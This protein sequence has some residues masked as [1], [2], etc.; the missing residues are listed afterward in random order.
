[1]TFCIENSHMVFTE[2]SSDFLK[3]VRFTIGPGKQTI[4]FVKHES[5]NN[6]SYQ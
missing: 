2:T 1:M 5:K 6:N 4:T 3:L